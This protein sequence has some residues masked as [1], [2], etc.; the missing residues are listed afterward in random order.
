MASPRSS[1]ARN[2]AKLHPAIAVQDPA[3]RI[4]DA[5]FW[6]RFG[7]E[8]EPTTRQKMIFVTVDDVS[9][10]GPATFNATSMTQAVGVAYSLVNFHFGSRDEL[11][12]EAMRY[13][14]T[15]YVQDV[16]D[17]VTAATRTPEVRMKTWIEAVADKAEELRGWGSVINYPTAS[18]EVSGL[19]ADK[20]GQEMVDLAELN[21]ARVLMLISD[22]KRGSL[23]KT[24]PE[25]GKVS[26]ISLLK[27]PV[28]TAEAVSVMMSTNGLAVWRA[29]RSATEISRQKSIEKLLTITHVKRI[30]DSLKTYS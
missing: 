27:N 19:V 14:Y 4:L 12:A 5:S 2:V 17:K 25:L 6:L 18:L 28:K 10:V 23:S 11:L 16:W 20:F 24:E 29:G 3:N 21:L 13:V 8:P 15:S 30:M 26:S 9:R 22:L 1:S 7:D